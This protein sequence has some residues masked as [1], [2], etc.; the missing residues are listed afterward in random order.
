[1]QQSGCFGFYRSEILEADIHSASLSGPA[2]ERLQ[3]LVS[4]L[5]RHFLPLDTALRFS[6]LN[7]FELVKGQRPVSPSSFCICSEHF[8]T[9]PVGREPI[10][11]GSMTDTSGR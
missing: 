10:A 2:I 7:R 11:L 5:V 1:M 8:A 9:A 6:F 3:P 4:S